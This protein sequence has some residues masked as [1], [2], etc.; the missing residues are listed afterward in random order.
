MRLLLASIAL[1]LVSACTGLPKNI[2]PV[3]GFDIDRYTGT[4][5]EIAR[6]DHS[7]ERGLS[8]VTATYT[9]RDDG[10]ITVTNKGYLAE[11]DKWKNAEGKAY[12]VKDPATGHLK[13]S[14]FGPFYGSYVIFELDQLNYEYAFVTGYNKKFLWLLARTPKVRDSVLE[15]FRQSIEAKGYDPAKLIAVWHDEQS[16]D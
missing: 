3:T 15:K 8:N 4:W 1:L 7:F 5:Y 2:T 16:A 10:G 6:Y 9:P 14:F 13:V 11:K 12:F